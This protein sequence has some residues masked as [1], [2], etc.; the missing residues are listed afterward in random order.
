MHQAD[1]IDVRLWFRILKCSQKSHPSLGRDGGTLRGGRCRCT[2]GVGYLRAGHRSHT[3]RVRQKIPP[4]TKGWQSAWTTRLRAG[5]SV[6]QSDGS[7][8]AL[9][10]DS[11]LGGRAVAGSSVASCPAAPSRPTGTEISTAAPSCPSPA[12][13][14][15]FALLQNPSATPTWASHIPPFCKATLPT[16]TIRQLKVQTHRSL[17]FSQAVYLN[18]CF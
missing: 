16:R 13:P 10:H 3:T 6:V 15:C 2:E 12:V 11:W 9:G 1:T 18:L 4:Q 8:T 17:H 14:Y 5:P 7:G